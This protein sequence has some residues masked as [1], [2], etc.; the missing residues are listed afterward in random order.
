[1]AGLPLIG[2]Y[3]EIAPPKA[4][5]KGPVP[6]RDEKITDFCR[7]LTDEMLRKEHTERTEVGGK[8]DD[9]QEMVNGLELE[10]RKRGLQ[11]QR[12]ISVGV[13]RWRSSSSPEKGT[14][15][16]PTKRAV[17]PSSVG[18]AIPSSLNPAYG[19]HIKKGLKKE[20]QLIWGTARSI[21]RK[22]HRQVQ[23]PFALA[24]MKS[25]CWLLLSKQILP[26]S[27]GC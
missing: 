24:V 20:L 16:P 15:E 14:G 26:T 6:T 1:M 8:T 17:T 10:M 25:H 23:G 5:P 19:N 12:W 11:Q 21:P 4:P 13:G 9:E 2:K 7:G 18:E 3:P 27:D 22:E